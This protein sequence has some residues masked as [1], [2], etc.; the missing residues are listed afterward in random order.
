MLGVGWTEMLVIGVVALIV[1]GP[2][3][4]PM[5]MQRLGKV[6]GTIRRMGNEFQ[7]EINK[8][9]GLDQVRDLRK[10]ITEPLRQTG[11]E[12]AKEFNAMSKDGSVQPTG[13]L[14]PSD[15]KVESV[16]DTIQKAV[17]MTQA[18]EAAAAAAT[19]AVTA[20]VVL[21]A[22]KPKRVAK[23]KPVPTAP[24]ARTDLAPIVAEPTPAA[25]RPA[26]KKPQAQK[27]AEPSP[28]PAEAMTP[29]K[30]VKATKKPAKVAETP[31]PAAP[32]AKKAPAK[33]APA[34]PRAEKG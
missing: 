9:T 10:S 2:K 4:L 11:A 13:V 28:A 34:A 21:T 12:I 1:I 33:K 25:K 3:D 27:T 22:A 32:A 17:G 20:P 30:V 7:R 14:K 6:I 19:P 16:Y 23:A 31:K 29:A 5:M 15:P 24:V 26:A 18:K 8:T